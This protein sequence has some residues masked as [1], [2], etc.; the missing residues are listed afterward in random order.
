MQYCRKKWDFFNSDFKSARGAY[1]AEYG[2]LAPN[3]SSYR[4]YH[5]AAKLDVTEPCYYEVKLAF[6]IERVRQSISG[7]RHFS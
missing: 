7:I 1:Y 3:L 4:M 6:K 2:K 5:M